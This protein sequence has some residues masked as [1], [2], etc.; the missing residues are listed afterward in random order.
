VVHVAPTGEV[1]DGH[2]AMDVHRSLG[3]TSLAVLVH[4]KVTDAASA[5]ISMNHLSS[6]GWLRDAVVAM[7]VMADAEKRP[8]PIPIERLTRDPKQARDLIQLATVEWWRFEKH[9]MVEDEDNE[10]IYQDR[11]YIERVHT[12]FEN[13][14]ITQITEA[15]VARKGTGKSLTKPRIRRFFDEF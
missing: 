4:E 14:D 7:H 1:I 8:Q 3:Q 5:Y 13:K 11:E 2:V 10:G 6:Q 9:G 12:A 15:D